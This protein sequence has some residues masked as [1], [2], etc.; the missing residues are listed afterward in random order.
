VLHSPNGTTGYG[1]LLAYAPQ[2]LASATTKNKLPALD[3]NSYIGIAVDL[4][5]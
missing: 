2:A 4:A 1:A 5:P 3:G